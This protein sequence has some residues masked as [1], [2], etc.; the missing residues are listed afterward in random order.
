[1]KACKGPF[2]I[3]TDEWHIGSDE[4]RVDEGG[5]F[6]QGWGRGAQSCVY[7]H[8]SFPFV[9]FMPTAK[10]LEAQALLLFI[11]YFVVV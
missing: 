3:G 4:P 9:P 5:I 1:V 10:G 6:L 8:M 7:L 2:F 11:H